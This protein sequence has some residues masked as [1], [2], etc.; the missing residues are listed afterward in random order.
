MRVAALALVALATVWP[1]RVRWRVAVAALGGGAVVVATWPASFAGWSN[2]WAVPVVCGAVVAVWWATPTVGRSL[3]VLGGRWLLLGGCAVAVYACVP[4]TDQLWEVAVALT[5]GALAE[6]LLRRALPT[7]LVAAAAAWV[8]WSAA[9]GATGRGSA[10]LAGSFAVAPFVVVA[11]VDRFVPVL[12]AAAESW[13]WVVA[14]VWVLAAGFAA[15]T[16]GLDRRTWLGVVAVV[17]MTAG[18][19]VATAAVSAGLAAPSR[20][21]HSAG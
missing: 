18:A 14:A 1:V 21:S 3:P 15:R 17:V 13:R 6:V 2:L 4:E 7:A 20:R 16:G 8:V 10:L 11:V 9:F 12:A 5:A 19:A